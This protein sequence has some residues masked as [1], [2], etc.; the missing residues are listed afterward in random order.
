MKRISLAV[1]LLSFAMP[2]FA[3][4]DTAAP[5]DDPMAGWVPRKVTNERG[6]KKQIEALFK[7]M[8]DAGRKGDLN[9][10]AALVDF[11]VLMVTDDSKGEGMGDT[12]SREKWMQVMAPLYKPMPDMKVSHKPDIFM[13]SDS[14]ASVDDRTTMTM[15]KKKMTTRSST[16]VIRKGGKWLIKS[17]VEGGWGD[18]MKENPATA[19]QPTPPSGTSA[20]PVE[21]Q[22]ASEQTTK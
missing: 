15:G 2:A 9:A 22:G 4:S 10:A 8:E 11:P 19:S 12:W 6:D 16:L 18:S 17:M 21:M 14:L 1:T 3:Q 13:I 5:G 20:V 7:S